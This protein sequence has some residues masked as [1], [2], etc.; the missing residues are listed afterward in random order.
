MST[1][2]VVEEVPYKHL[3]GRPAF[4]LL[5]VDEALATQRL[6]GSQGPILNRNR[7]RNFAADG[8]ADVP[9]Q[10]VVMS[11]FVKAAGYQAAGPAVAAHQHALGLP[12]ALTDLGSDETSINFTHMDSGR[13]AAW[14]AAEG[15][16]DLRTLGLNGRRLRDPSTGGA[17]CL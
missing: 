16:R 7:L 8:F 17:R 12:W 13:G 14:L 4:S 9:P 15:Q 11:G 3:D 10:V 2:V 1:K 5:L 6:P